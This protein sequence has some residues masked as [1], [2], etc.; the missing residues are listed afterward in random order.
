MNKKLPFCI[1]SLIM[2][3]SFS[4][5]A[6]SMTAPQADGFPKCKVDESKMKA[7]LM[8]YHKDEDH[9]LHFA[10]SWD[11][12][13]FKAL[14]NDNPV[15]AGDTVATQKG[16]RDPHIYR[17][18][19]GA[20]YMA[21]TDL[22]VYGQRDGKR[23][24][25]W[26]RPR[27]TYGWG[28]NKGIVMMKSWNLINWTHHNIH[29]DKLFT[30][31]QEIGCAWAPETIFDEQA[32][33]YMVYLTMRHKDEPAKLYYAYANE[34]FDSIETEP[35]V[36]FQY[37]DE[38]ISAIDGDITKVG[39][40]Y[41]LMYVSHDGQAGIK[42]ATSDRPTGGWHYD[43]RWVDDAPVGCEAPHVYKLIGENK[44]ILMY[45]IYRMKP[46]TFGFV[47]TT[48]FNSYKSLGIFN[49]GKMRTLN[50]SSPKH[51]AVVQITAEEADAL[52]R[53]WNENARTYECY[54]PQIAPNVNNPVI[55]GFY[56]DPEIMFSEKTG[57]Y[58]LYP[59]TDGCENWQNHDAHVY[60]SAD[61]KTWKKEGVALDLRKDVTWANEKLWAP[62]IIE[63][64]TGEGAKAKYQYYYYFVADGSI[65]VAV[66][67]RPEGPFRDALGK[68]LLKQPESGPM[69]GHL[70]DP[71]VFRDPQSGKYY[72]YWGN[73]FLMVAELS[74]DMLSIKDS[75]QQYVIPR[76]MQGQYHYCEGSYVFYRNGKYYFTWSEN[77]TRSPEYRVRYTMSDS[78]TKL[79]QPLRR[80]VVIAKDPSK[81]IYGTGHHAVICK[82]GTDEWYI[83]YHRFERP[84]GLKRGWS[85]GYYREVCIDRLYFNDDGTIK[86]VE[87]T[88]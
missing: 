25:E 58:Y 30:S 21:M 59:T 45:D 16:I 47:E 84:D 69:R 42:H 51:G 63:R 22:H 85:A 66:A 4:A 83:V 48:D 23:D 41:H 78:P 6:N 44:W 81:Q 52:E 28:N 87:P 61:M 80:N 49:N 70:I 71:D 15:I 54:V 46:M 3:L 67:D 72:L 76:S 50:F 32:G 68:P 74:D 79:T 10:I 86:S 19:D 7:Y 53:Y 17:G 26:E 43:A 57:K 9:G 11:G 36:L 37:P 56:A 29:F 73:A 14:N 5:K 31:W 33:R 12:R 39:D 2:S 20:F 82:P 13:Q 24:T 38:G 62:C 77:D 65:G 55:P 18:P 40:T 8:V 64:K 88:L 27:K 34:A 75:T 60:S 35:A 1:V